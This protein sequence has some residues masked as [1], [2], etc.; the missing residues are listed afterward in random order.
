MEF[1]ED[2]RALIQKRKE[3]CESF[4][5]LRQN[6]SF[7]KWSRLQFSVTHL[8]FFTDLFLQSFLIKY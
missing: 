6:F 1:D 7:I 5:H 8:C 2:E 4:A 3:C